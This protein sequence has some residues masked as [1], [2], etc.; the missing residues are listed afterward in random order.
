MSSSQK[1]I[2][3]LRDDDFDGLREEYTIFAEVFFGCGCG[4]TTKRCLVTRAIVFEPELSKHDDTPLSSNS[5][6]SAQASSKDCEARD[7][8][9]ASDKWNDIIEPECF[10]E[11]LSDDKNGKAKRLKLS[12][13]QFEQSKVIDNGV[14]HPVIETSITYRLVESSSGGVTSS[15]YLLNKPIG[16]TKEGDNQEDSPTCQVSCSKDNNSIAV[17]VT[18]SVASPISEES[19]AAKLLVAGPS[20]A[21]IDQFTLPHPNGKDKELTSHGPQLPNMP[22]GSKFMKD[23]RRL[24]QDEINNLLEATGWQFELRKRRNSRQRFSVYLSPEGKSFREFPKVWQMLGQKLLGKKFKLWQ[25]TKGKHWTDIEQFCFD[26]MEA[27]MHINIS[28]DQCD[29]NKALADVWILL[30]PFVLVAFI[31]KKIGVLRKRN[32]VGAT[33]GLSINQHGK[34]EASLSL[35]N[36]DVT[37]HKMALAWRCD[38]PL[39]VET[40]SVV[41]EGNEGI[42]PDSIDVHACRDVSSDSHNGNNVY[43]GG[44]DR[45]FSRNYQLHCPNEIRLQ[46]D[47]YEHS[48]SNIASLPAF[49]DVSILQ[50]KHGNMSSSLHTCRLLQEGEKALPG[51]ETVIC[52]ESSGDDVNTK[53]KMRQKSKKISEIKGSSLCRKNTLSLKSCATDEIHYTAQ[54]TQPEVREN[55]EIIGDIRSPIEGS[56]IINGCVDLQDCKQ[57]TESRKTRQQSDEKTSNE[58]MKDDDLSGSAILQKYSCLSDK[59]MSMKA[60]KPKYKRKLKSQRGLRKLQTLAVAKKRN[61]IDGK[62][63][64]MGPRTVLSWLVDIGAVSLND[65]IQCRDV[66]YHVPVK[67]GIVTK[68]GI[69][70]RCCNNVFSVSKFKMHAGANQNHH[71]SNLFLE[72]GK[73]YT[74]CL[75]QAWSAD[76][77]TRKTS[78]KL[79]QFE[80]LDSNDDTCG[81]CGDGGDLICCDGCP[82]TFHQMCLATQ[83]LPD[84]NWY[85]SRCICRICGDL[86]SN[87]SRNLHGLEC[88]QCETK[89]HEACLKEMGLDDVVISETWFCGRNCEEVSNN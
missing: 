51:T 43:L 12:I 75:L 53:K 82:S 3:D 18:K 81:I 52:N 89:Y 63:I 73:S 37:G 40:K 11:T 87:S 72:N 21:R 48:I 10:R 46:A 70:C 27:L 88:R 26:L 42:D 60:A 13:G 29:F 58:Q 25:Q 78:R 33:R 30:H 67:D 19:F 14:S 4:S 15:S 6:Q 54:S 16:V 17:A 84:G 45:N 65:V 8:N 38:S 76:Y 66:R 50:G 36:P 31:E 34:S 85:C 49:E 1:G 7:D 55:Q 35:E 20:V 80:D 62:Y 28:M 77:K 79:S 83:D 57:V 74:T 68:D 23:P 22:A 41:V 47:F 9:A 56:V 86:V 24:I 71:F 59:D 5:L 64:P 32:V 39:T 44:H 61:F 2:D 69:F